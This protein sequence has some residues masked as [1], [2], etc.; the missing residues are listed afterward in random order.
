MGGSG[1]T[2][3]TSSTGST[4]G[5]FAT[6]GGGGDT[7]T[8]GGGGTVGA[9]GVTGSAGGVTGSAGGTGG[10]VGG[11]S[12]SAQF[13][14][15]AAS[16]AEPALRSD[17]LIVIDR[18]SSMSDDS[19]ETVCTGGCGPSSKFEVL[20]AAL[21]QLVYENPSVNWGLAFYPTD[22]ACG[23][24][25]GAAVDPSPNAP[26]AIE[27]TLPTM[28]PGGG[29][30]PTAAAIYA[31]SAYLQ[32]RVDMNRKYILLATD[33]RSGCATGDGG[34]ADTEAEDA[35][36]SALFGGIPTYVVGIVPSSDI[37]ATSTLNQMADL[38]GEPVQGVEGDFLSIAELGP[39]F[40]PATSSALSCSLYLPFPIGPDTTLAVQALTGGG[41]VWIDVPEDP[42]NGWSFTS[43][44][45]DGVI[46]NGSA[47]T[48]TMDGSYNQFQLYYGCP[49]PPLLEDERPV[50]E[51]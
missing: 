8:T 26:P 15:T 13:C 5:A 43:P 38:G 40:A 28:M 3:G 2:G 34:A 11:S 1:D 6:G 42:S 31:A 25:A 17:I 49:G 10:D 21:D 16:Y 30:A 18:S 36:T 29:D 35:I 27:S 46:L 51:R 12:G 37:T 33:G 9:G 19:N 45:L 39:S 23:V 7:F 32:S 48:S 44:N 22:D 47:C 24:T 41:S 50:G 20:S 4:G 14:G